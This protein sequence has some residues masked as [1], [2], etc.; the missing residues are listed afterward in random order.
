[1]IWDTAKRARE[2]PFEWAQR[3][4]FPD[5]CDDISETRGH[6]VM[7]TLEENCRASEPGRA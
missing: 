4:K 1:M 5:T 3:E 7:E 2:K 6:C